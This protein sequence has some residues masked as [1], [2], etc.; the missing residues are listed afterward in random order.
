MT[1]YSISRHSDREIVKIV[2]VNGDSYFTKQFAGLNRFGDIVSVATIER[3]AKSISYDWNS[4]FFASALLGSSKAD[5][6]E[7]VLD[8]MH[9]MLET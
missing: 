1:T 9:S 6:K 3:G 7:L 2:R 5:G 8:A 4:I